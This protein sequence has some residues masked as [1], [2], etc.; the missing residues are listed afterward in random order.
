MLFFVA[1]CKPQTIWFVSFPTATSLPVRCC[2]LPPHRHQKEPC[3]TLT[4]TRP[5]Y[6]SSLDPPPP[7]PPGGGGGVPA[8]PPPPC[9]GGGT[10]EP[11]GSRPKR[12]FPPTQGGWL[13]AG[14][15]LSSR[16]LTEAWF[17]RSPPL[18]KHPFPI[19]YNAQLSIEAGGND[20]ASPPTSLH[21][22]PHTMEPCPRSLITTTR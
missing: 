16:C 4:L 19:P 21:P 13:L 22:P 9:E 18:L 15:P 5:G 11:F 6:F 7:P 17:S 12:I 2:P 20:V 3:L 1:I 10:P 8:P 14:P